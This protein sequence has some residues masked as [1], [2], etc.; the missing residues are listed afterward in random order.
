MGKRSVWKRLLSML[1]VFVLAVLCMSLMDF[2]GSGKTEAA[3]RD[4]KIKNGVLLDYYGDGGDIVVPYGVT[5]IGRHAFTFE[6]EVYS[7]ELPKSVTVI[8]DEALPIA[9][10]CKM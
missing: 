7:V 2:S 3:S 1:A 5:K 6:D 4:F 9:F 10:C 8:E